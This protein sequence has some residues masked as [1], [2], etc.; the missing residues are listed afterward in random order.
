MGTLGQSGGR[1]IRVGS[2]G[3][4]F[5]GRLKYLYNVQESVKI[6]YN[7]NLQ[8]S[9][10]LN[11]SLGKKREQTKLIIKQKINNI[12]NQLQYLDLFTK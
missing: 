9:K 11:K 12:I 4:F 8:L 10:S 2:F 6:H 1:S 3:G 5:N 7:N